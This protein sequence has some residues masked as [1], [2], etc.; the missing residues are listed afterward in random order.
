MLLFKWSRKSLSQNH[1]M[2]I[3]WFTLSPEKPL[4]E[5]PLYWK[6]IPHSLS[7]AFVDL[8]PPE[9]EVKNSSLRESTETVKTVSNKENSPF[10]QHPHQ[11]T[12]VSCIRSDEFWTKHF[13]MGA[14]NF[15]HV[16]TRTQCCCSPWGKK[17][18]FIFKWAIQN[19]TLLLPSFL[20]I[21]LH[22]LKAPCLHFEDSPKI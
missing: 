1:S 5:S 3:L 20:F 17:C 13:H 6:A 16:Q 21:H 9:H 7:T 19:H 4:P 18:A 15:S 8:P 2:I 10:S 11:V 12:S 22:L 14:T